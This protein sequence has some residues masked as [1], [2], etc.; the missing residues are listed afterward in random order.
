M[1]VKGASFILVLRFKHGA[2]ASFA[3]FSGPLLK[4]LE[5][6][7]ATITPFSDRMDANFH[8]FKSAGGKTTL[9]HASVCSHRYVGNYE[10]G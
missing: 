5:R 2:H 3:C 8:A 4:I 7:M 1:T 6:P 10:Y 9:C